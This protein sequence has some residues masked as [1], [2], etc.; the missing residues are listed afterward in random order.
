MSSVQSRLDNFTGRTEQL[1][2]NFHSLK[3][4][5]VESHCDELEV[6][7]KAE[8]AAV[9][10]DSTGLRAY[11]PSCPSWLPPAIAAIADAIPGSKTKRQLKMVRIL[12]EEFAIEVAAMEPVVNYI[13]QNTRK[14]L[15]REPKKCMQLLERAALIKLDDKQL[16]ADI[17]KVFKMLPELNLSLKGQTKKMNSNFTLYW[18]AF[19][20]VSELILLVKRHLSEGKRVSDEAIDDIVLRMDDI[21]KV[22]RKMFFQWEQNE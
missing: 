12:I 19:I 9:G 4:K 10:R 8:N 22:Y 18:Q 7:L 21:K 11:L 5:R 3:E 13:V 17:E 16:I 20:Q 1:I 15:N 2:E 14:E 6:A